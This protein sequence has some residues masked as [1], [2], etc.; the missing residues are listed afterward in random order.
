MNKSMLSGIPALEPRRSASQLVVV[1]VSG[2]A[3]DSPLL[4]AG[5]RHVVSIFAGLPC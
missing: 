2:E 3:L 4:P 5:L 1:F